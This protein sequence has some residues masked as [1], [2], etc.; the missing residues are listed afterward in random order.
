MWTPWSNDEAERANIEMF[1]RPATSP[2][3]AVYVDDGADNGDSMWTPWSDDEA[4]RANLEMFSRPA[5]PPPAVH[6]DSDA[7]DGVGGDDVDSKGRRKGGG[8]A[9]WST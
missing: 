8:A 1:S 7:G 4:E 6:V 2:P 3:A 9:W 5:T